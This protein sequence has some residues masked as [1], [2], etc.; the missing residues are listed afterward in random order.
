MLGPLS[1]SLLVS[2]AKFS[3]L[4][5]VLWFRSSLTLKGSHGSISRSFDLDLR[6]KARR[7]V[8]QVSVVVTFTESEG[9]KDDTMKDT[10]HE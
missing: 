1:V 3:T 6:Q 2:L 5:Q 10:T 8:R 9:R 7:R 4:L